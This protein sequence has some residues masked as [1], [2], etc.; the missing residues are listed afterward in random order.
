[1]NVSGSETPQ[2]LTLSE[3]LHAMLLGWLAWCADRRAPRRA[4]SRGAAVVTVTARA[5]PEVERFCARWDMTAE[6]TATA[7][8][9]WAVLRVDGP[10]L[11][12]MGFSAIT[13]MYRP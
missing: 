5:V 4:G 9:R 13:D 11:P 8:G 10:V 12:V 1:M 3:K 2:P 7:D 6:R